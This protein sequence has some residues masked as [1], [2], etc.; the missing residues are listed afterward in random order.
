MSTFIVHL[1][2]KIIQNSHRNVSLQHSVSFRRVCASV[3]FA[4]LC[5]ISLA[6]FVFY[7]PLGI[8]N[9]KPFGVTFIIWTGLQADQ[10][11]GGYIIYWPHLCFTRYSKIYLS[12][13]TA[14]GVMVPR[15]RAIP[16]GKPRLSAV[17]CQAFPTTVRDQ[18][19]VTAFWFIAQ[20]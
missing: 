16:T 18:L 5:F 17:S 6:W 8:G 19:T 10:A 13:A 12:Y 7:V 2:M 9:G 1:E 3:F 4:I 15:E 20:R 14:A 11:V